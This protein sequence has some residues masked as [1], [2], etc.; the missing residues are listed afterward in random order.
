M[1]QRM[2]YYCSTCKYEKIKFPSLFEALNILNRA[3]NKVSEEGMKK[4]D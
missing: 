4:I 2:N 3:K 1:W